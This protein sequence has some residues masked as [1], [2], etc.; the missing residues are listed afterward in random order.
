MPENKNTNLVVLAVNLDH[1]YLHDQSANDEQQ[2]LKLTFTH[3]KQK[4]HS[5]TKKHQLITGKI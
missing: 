3:Y 5:N 1:S 4:T 2:Q